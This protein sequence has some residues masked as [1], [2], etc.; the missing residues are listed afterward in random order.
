M[1]GLIHDIHP[2]VGLGELL[3]GTSEELVRAQLGEPPTATEKDYGDGVNHRDW[4]YEW[5]SLSLSFSQDNDYRLITIT[6]SYEWA[7][8]G[9]SR[10]IGLTEAELCA[11]DSDGLGP[12]RFDDDFE[13]FGKDYYWDAL[14]LS[15][16]L[17]DGIVDSVT[18]MPLYDESGDISQWRNHAG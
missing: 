12:P 6:T 15:C 3:L 1:L 2:G 10:I 17:T 18:I 13:E 7:T 14:N 5:L 9:E 8:L 16:W 11:S 4:D